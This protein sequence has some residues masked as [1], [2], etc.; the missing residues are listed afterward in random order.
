MFMCLR[1][2]VIGALFCC[3]LAAAMLVHVQP[4]QGA[5]ASSLP[6]VNLPF[7]S[8]AG[9]FH[10]GTSPRAEFV[11]MAPAGAGDISRSGVILGGLYIDSLVYAAKNGYRSSSTGLGKL[12]YL[13]SYDAASSIYFVPYLTIY[14]MMGI[15]YRDASGTD[16]DLWDHSW[17]LIGGQLMVRLG[18][19][20][21]CH[22]DVEPYSYTRIGNNYRVLAGVSR[23]VSQQVAVSAVYERTEWDTKV[24]KDGVPFQYAGG[25][26]SMYLKG[27]Y[28]FMSDGKLSGVNLFASYGYE[29][30]INSGNNTVLAPGDIG[31]R[32]QMLYFGV[33]LG[34][35]SW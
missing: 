27:I 33:A 34:K 24:N 2:M 6:E 1:R 12:Y 7:F 11:L 35:I 30:I 13:P 9:R 16:A 4:A 23:A 14:R 29:H 17:G 22:A 28:R 31:E 18:E 20:W 5:D 15:W 32:G 21:A 3:S 19:A 26:E 25:S 10:S 8:L